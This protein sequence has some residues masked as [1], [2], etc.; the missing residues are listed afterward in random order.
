M[1]PSVTRSEKIISDLLWYGTGTAS[2][3]VALGLVRGL[4]NPLG[5]MIAK[6][7][8][9]LFILLP[10]MRVAFLL[11]MFAQE[12]DAIYVVITASVLTIIAISVVMATLTS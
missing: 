1:K 5:L 2:A 4:G 3:L 12:R 9:A 8:I 10:I 6:S 11:K 7:G